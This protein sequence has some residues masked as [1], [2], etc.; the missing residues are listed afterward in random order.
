MNVLTTFRLPPANIT[1]NLLDVMPLLSVAQYSSNNHWSGD[2]GHL[3]WLYQSIPLTRDL[4]E[5][6]PKRRSLT[7]IIYVIAYP[8]IDGTWLWWQ[9]HIQFWEDKQKKGKCQSLQNLTSKHSTIQRPPFI[10][11]QAS[12]Q[13]LDHPKNMSTSKQW[14]LLL[15]CINVTQYHLYFRKQKNFH[16]PLILHN[17]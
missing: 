3:T 14:A 6:K 4:H 12:L 11:V 16:A 7:T 10:K 13:I 5:K 8:T 9:V 15:K 2:S 1:S 17:L